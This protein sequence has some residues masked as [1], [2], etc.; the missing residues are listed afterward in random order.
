V[1][2]EQSMFRLDGRTAV[3][4]GTESLL[5]AAVVQ[6]LVD[7][8]AHVL[9][10][11]P[12]GDSPPRVTNLSAAIAQLPTLDVLVNLI[13]LDGSGAIRSVSEEELDAVI[14]ATVESSFLVSQAAA[15][16]M[17]A[18]S[19]GGHS[20]AIIHVG[21]PLARVGAAER[22]LSCMAMHALRG[23]TIASAV[24][25][26]PVG[27]RVNLLEANLDERRERALLQPPTAAGV[28]SAIVY[29]ASPAASAMTGS[30]LLLD[31][32][33]TAR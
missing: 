10:L 23:L 5:T 15:A 14:E 21:T 18:R 3:V 13:G 9:D 29:L 28:A 27:I 22:S 31:A 19:G 33:W 30:S 6:A 8:G 7:A 2:T 24:E 17:S 1:N 25:L 26:G 32:G 16:K 12:A 11:L 4:L 20:A